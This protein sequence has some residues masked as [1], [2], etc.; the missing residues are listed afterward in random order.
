MNFNEFL[1]NTDKIVNEL[2]DCGDDDK[3]D[4]L[5]KKFKRNSLSFFNSLYIYPEMISEL[6]VQEIYSTIHNAAKHKNHYVYQLDYRTIIENDEAAIKSKISD[7]KILLK[8][9]FADMAEIL[10]DEIISKI[11]DST[12][13]YFDPNNKD[14]IEIIDFYGYFIHMAL[15]RTNLD[16]NYYIKRRNFFNMMVDW[17]TAFHSYLVNKT[18]AENHYRNIFVNIRIIEFLAFVVQKI[19][20]QKNFNEIESLF[21][22][23]S[24]SALNPELR[25][26]L[27]LNQFFHLVN[28]SNIFTSTYKNIKTPKITIE[29]LMHSQTIFLYWNEF[30]TIA[31][32][33]DSIINPLFQH[34]NPKKVED[35]YT[36]KFENCLY[37]ENISRLKNYKNKIY[38]P[39]FSL[40]RMLEKHEALSSATEKA[41]DALISLYFDR[42]PQNV[43]NVIRNVFGGLMQKKQIG[44][45]EVVALMEKHHDSIEQMFKEHFKEHLIHYKEHDLLYKRMKYL[46]DKMED[47]IE[48][49]RVQP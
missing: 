4:E 10:L 45:S 35:F 21:I 25:I 36:L 46:E 20:Q 14:H 27:S 38:K 3:I 29:S 28:T 19:S 12:S 34:K 33:F 18:N 1:D 39:R 17:I 47:M 49:E 2:Q 24:N 8:N 11:G 30:T 22:T 5:I 23:A 6:S 43:I 44:L 15:F 31:V 9:S 42:S 48:D 41:L 13:P 26:G 40:R 32:R 37:I 16:P 7:F